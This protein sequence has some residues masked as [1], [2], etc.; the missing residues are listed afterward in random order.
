[1]ENVSE[2]ITEIAEE[3]SSMPAS[4]LAS[5]AEGFFGSMDSIL[6][7]LKIMGF[8][9]VGI[10]IVT[11]VIILLVTLLNTITSGTKKKKDKEN[12]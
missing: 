5:E 2:I 6:E 3:L 1:M 12:N 10:F 7:S 9:M 11:I 4:E 8:G